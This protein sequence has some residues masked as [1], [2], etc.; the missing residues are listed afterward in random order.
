ET[1]ESYGIVAMRL[2]LFLPKQHE[3]FYASWKKKSSPR[4]GD[5]L[6]N[7]ELPF[8][9]NGVVVGRLKVS[10]DLTSSSC[11]QEMLSF[12]DYL[13]QIEGEVQERMNQDVPPTPD[14]MEREVESQQVQTGA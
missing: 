8:V 6:W 7:M 14:R 5:H 10:G 13:K 12:L 4:P 9:S 11:L 2:N 1:A 3:N